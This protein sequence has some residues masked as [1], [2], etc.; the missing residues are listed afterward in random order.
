M[1]FLGARSSRFG[2]VLLVLLAALKIA[3]AFPESSERIEKYMRRGQTTESFM[4]MS[5]RTHYWE[6]AWPKIYE[7]PVWGWGFQ[8]D[9]FLGLTH[10]H[11]TYLYA[12]LTSGFLGGAAF[13]GG[14]IWTWLLFFRTMGNAAFRAGERRTMLI[15][16]GGILAFFTVR[17]IPE[18]CGALFGVDTMVM[19]P[20]L[21]FIISSD[22]LL[23]SGRPASA[24]VL[25]APA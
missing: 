15:Q 14:L 7:S 1:L 22:K 12:F 6:R 4:S 20:A 18:V 10:I 24:R 5:G 17:S 25:F 16:T 8:S 19:I 3:G 2:I 21:C 11:N 13:T 23:R 9:R